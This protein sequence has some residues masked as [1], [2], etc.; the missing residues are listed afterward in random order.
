MYNTHE[1]QNF[2]PSGLDSTVLVN[3]FNSSVASFQ[4][5]LS[6]FVPGLSTKQIGEVESL[7]Y[8][9][10]GSTETIDSYDTSYIRAGLIYRDVVLACPA[11]WIAS[12]ATEKGYLGEYTISPAT[13]GSD[14]IYVCS[15]LFIAIFFFTWIISWF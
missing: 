1:G 11:Y 5:W 7:Y 6:G 15:S 12:A 14:T 13:H 3:G 8:P 4:Q 9:A 10:E 2:I